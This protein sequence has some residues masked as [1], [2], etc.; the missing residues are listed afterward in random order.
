M[1][2]LNNGREGVHSA[3]SALM[4]GDTRGKVSRNPTFDQVCVLRP[5]MAGHPTI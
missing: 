3:L 1:G 5:V 2:V 4:G